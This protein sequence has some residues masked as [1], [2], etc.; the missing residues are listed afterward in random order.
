VHI[1]HNA[2]SSE[3]QKY[4]NILDAGLNILYTGLTGFQNVMKVKGR[5]SSLLTGRFQNSVVVKSSKE[6]SWA[7]CVQNSAALKVKYPGVELFV[8]SLQDSRETSVTV[9]HLLDSVTKVR[10]PPC[11]PL[12]HIGAW[13]YRS[14]Q[15]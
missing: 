7:H 8:V 12:R 2:L 15:L 14:T 6:E 9:Q 3:C 13:R 4:K 10:L 5:G 1:F 11:M